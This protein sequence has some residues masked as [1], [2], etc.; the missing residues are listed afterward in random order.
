MCIR[1]SPKTGST[2]WQGPGGG[3]STPT[4]AGDI[5]LVHGKP[6]EV[7]LIAFRNIKGKILE[8]WRFPKLSRRAESSPL[9]F[10]G[11]AFLIGAG[12][13]LSLDLD[14][15]K[16]LRQVPSKHEI[17]SAILANGRIFAFEINGSFLN[18]FDARKGDFAD[19]QRFK[20]NALKCTSPALVGSKI[21]IRTS[22]NIKCYEL[23]NLPL[24]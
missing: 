17:S 1:D 13:R 9:I 11:K 18:S 22:E 7:G 2:T 8:E 4:A 12:L 20:V 6:E 23:G 10:D 19:E 5:L 16:V 21:L 14:S 15:G 24:N 3:S